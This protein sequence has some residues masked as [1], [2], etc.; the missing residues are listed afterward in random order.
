MVRR[1]RL[2][3]SQSEL[4]FGDSGGV[5]DTAYRWHPVVVPPGQ[6]GLHCVAR[7]DVEGHSIDGDAARL[8]R[9]DGGDL[10]AHVWVVGVA[11][12]VASGRQR[13]PASEYQTACTAVR[14]PGGY[15]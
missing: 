4:A 9:Q 3:A 12:P 7:S 1:R 8:Q 6:Q 5:Y 11:V 10:V 14:E 13:R 2:S 15:Q